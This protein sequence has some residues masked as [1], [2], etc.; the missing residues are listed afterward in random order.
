MI[1]K[2]KIKIERKVIVYGSWRLFWWFLC[3]IYRTA[4]VN[5][6]CDCYYLEFYL[7]ITFNN[8]A[9]EIIQ[10]SSNFVVFINFLSDLMVLNDFFRLFFSFEVLNAGFSLNCSVHTMDFRFHPFQ[11]RFT[12]KCI[13]NKHFANNPKEFFYL[14]PTRAI[15]LLNVS[16]HLKTFMMPQFYFN[17]MS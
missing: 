10:S 8:F 16:S 6:S 1:G 4:P 2:Y 17:T 11:V 3:Q 12:K 9:L 14:G 5:W 15:I 7:H 13:F